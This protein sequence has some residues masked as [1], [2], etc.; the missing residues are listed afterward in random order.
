MKKNRMMLSLLALCLLLSGCGSGAPAS[1]TPTP[2]PT[3]A[4][5]TPRPTPVIQGQWADAV[6]AMLAPYEGALARAAAQN[7]GN[8][9]YTIPG[10][11]LLQMAKDAED[12]GEAPR[13]GRLTFTWHAAVETSY[14]ATMD[15]AQAEMDILLPSVT[16]DPANET[17]IDAQQLGDYS[18]S[19]GG[20]FDRTRTYDVAESLTSGTAE[21]TELLN[22]DQTGHELFSFVLRGGSLY[23][24]D[25]ALDVSADLDELVIQEGYLVAVGV[26]RENGLD[27]V[28]YHLNDPTQLP[29]PATLDWDRLLAS[30]TPVSRLSVAVS[31]P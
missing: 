17:P 3:E 8:I 12:L 29:D 25:A 9:T 15:D 19:G 31:A 7:P 23:F 4:P 2:A 24:V 5:P 16:P 10:D 28:E 22:G 6:R 27:T 26:L 18:V 20:L 11:L 1:G 30:V 14:V 13:N 21:I